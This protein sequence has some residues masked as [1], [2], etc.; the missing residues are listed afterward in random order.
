MQ[1]EFAAHI[2]THASMADPPSV[3]ANTRVV[4]L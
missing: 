2:K 4:W 1:R 3:G